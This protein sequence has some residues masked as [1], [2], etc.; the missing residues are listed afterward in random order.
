[1][2]GVSNIKFAMLWSH[3]AERCFSCAHS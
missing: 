3:M 1:M 2:H